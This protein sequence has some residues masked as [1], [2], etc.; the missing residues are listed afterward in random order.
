MP[1]AP[2]LT[3]IFASLAFCA[4]RGGSA[5]ADQYDP[6]ASYYNSATGS[7]A[8]LKSQLHN[9]I[10]NHT[11]HSYDAA[12]TLLQVSDRDPS[13]PDRIILVYD[14]VS[15]D[16]SQIGG[17]I[18]GW[19]SG[20]SW[21]REH[22][23]PKVRGV[24]SGGPDYSDLHQLRPSTNSVNSDRG[25]LNF[26]GAFGQPFG[27]VFDKGASKW[28]PGDDDAGMIARQEFYMAVRYDGSD[29]GTEDLELYNGNPSTSQG[30]GD[31]ARLLEWHYLAPPDDFERS[32]NQKVFGY[33]NNRNPFI[34]RPEFV[35]SVFVDQNN[36][37]QLTL[38][39]GAG[40][41]GATALDV[42]MGRVI[43]GAAA[44]G[45]QTITLNKAGVDGTYYE[46]TATG[47]ATSS[48]TGRFNAFATGTT[49]SRTVSVGLNAT[50]S[51][52]GLQTGAVV[53][54][55]LDVTTGGGAGRGAQDGDDVANLSLAVLDH[56][57]PSFDGAT[58]V[59]TLS[60]DFG[61][62]A[63]GAG[64]AVFQ[65]D[66]YNLMATAGYTAAMELASVVGSGDTDALTL[67]ASPILDIDTIEAGHSATLTAA[68]ADTA[69]GDFSA[70][71]TL[72]Y[73]DEDLPGAMSVG[74]LLLQLTGKVVAASNADFDGDQ[75]VAGA[76]LLAWQRGFGTLAPNGTRDAGD[77]N[78]DANIDADDL[79]VW[80]AQYGS[81]PAPAFQAV[82]EP[83]TLALALL[84]AA[85]YGAAAVCRR[86]G[87]WLI[88]RR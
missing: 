6:P 79:G 4:L 25:N 27:Q 51:T 8:T 33:Q 14:R 30:M 2:R 83:R 65:F 77:A 70:T 82:P 81:A 71:Y 18:P 12:R 43:V 84:F 1:R 57:T 87:N 53:F 31:L 41:G 50:T 24:D 85:A 11:V 38:A 17:S 58:A 32:R 68:L 34:D 52:A 75:L 63:A 46:V 23:W 61:S 86:G 47:D 62:V 56:A 21:N 44:P 37:S 28:Y 5:L 66:V 13:D 29:G 48:V 42:D 67:D 45:A 40:S 15:L 59:T 20:V 69:D 19:D 39:G 55:N 88:P 7:G 60:Y 73:A 9:I 10:D 80:T 36:D 64:G 54:D 72:A 78:G 3:L 74:S 76:D 49:G 26:G 35:W 22:T 16:V